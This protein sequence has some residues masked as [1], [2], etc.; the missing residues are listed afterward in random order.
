MEKL[1]D[2][3]T[4][5]LAQA[6]ANGQ[7]PPLSNPPSSSATP[8]FQDNQ[9][10]SELSSMLLA[11]YDGL[12][13]YGKEPEQLERAN[14]L[15]QMVLAEFPIDKIR[16]AFAFYL[17]HDSGMPDPGDIAQIIL[18]GGN[19]PPFKNSVYVRL[20]QKRKDFPESMSREDWN[21]MDD[22]ERFITTGKY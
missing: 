8:L 18:R 5:T 9:G 13:T 22:Y 15:F 19:K 14:R 12:K 1:S 6:K 10:K 17:K 21:Y 4:K 2:I 20:A 7:E 11:C 16:Q 3:L